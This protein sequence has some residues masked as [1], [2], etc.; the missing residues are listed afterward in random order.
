MGIVHRAV[1]TDTG[2]TVALKTV[3]TQG[4]LTVDAIQREIH[5]L[6]SLDHPGIVR[7]LAHG[8]FEGAPWYAMELLE[9]IDL[10]QHA[11]ECFWPDHPPATVR[12][13]PA[14]AGGKLE[15]ALTL[16]RHLCEALAYLHGEGIVHRD[17]KPQ[18]IWIRPDGTPVLMDFGLIE[19]FDAAAAREV[20]HSGDHVTGTIFYMS[21]EQIRGEL[22]DARTDLY[23][24]GCI[25]YE[26]VTG[27][28]PFQGGDGFE[29]IKLHLRKEP[30]A[31]SLH[32]TGAPPELDGLLLALLAKGPKDRLG[33][34][35]VV[36]RTLA[37]LGAAS[38]AWPGTP[39]RPYLYRPSLAGRGPLLADLT[40]R[41]SAARSG[42]GSMTFLGGA[43]GSGKTRLAIALE[44]ELR[45]AG[46]DVRTG[47]CQPDSAAQ[48]G[49]VDSQPL[50]A[51]R[52]LLQDVA[53]RCRQLGADEADRLL[54]NRG[55]LLALY[56]PS[57]QGLPGQER[58]PEPGPLPLEAARQRLHSYLTETLRVLCEQKPVAIIL[59]DL[60]WA[61]D[62]TLDYLEYLLV[63]GALARL[64]LGLLA[65]YRDEETGPGLGALLSAPG[66]EVVKLE[67][68]QA[69]AIAEIAKD[70]LAI[71]EVPPPMTAF[72][73]HHSE[74]SPFFASE[75]LRTAVAEGL[76]TRT[77]DGSWLPA[78][79][80][81]TDTERSSW[82]QLQV[83]GTLRQLLQR[84]LGTL[85]PEA[86]ALCGAA[87]VLGKEGSSDVLTVTAELEDAARHRATQ[88]LLDRH[89]FEETRSS[90]FRFV[91]ETTRELVLE[92]IAPDRLRT[93]HRTAANALVGAG[94]HEEALARLANHWEQAGDLEQARSCYLASARQAK[95]VYA[96]REAE[97]RY[98][99]FLRL[100]PLPSNATVKARSEL[101]S[102]I[103]RVRGQ[104]DEAVTEL[105]RGIA[106]GEE[107][108]DRGGQVECLTG[109][110][111]I[112]MAT[113]PMARATESFERGVAMCRQ[114]GDRRREGVV[115][116]NL[117]SLRF[118]QGRMDEARELYQQSLAIDRELS[119]RRGEGITLGN[120]A[121]LDHT[122]GHREEARLLYEQA[123][124]IAREVGDPQHEGHL[125]GNLAILA[126]T[127]GDL[128]RAEALYGDALRLAGETGNRGIEGFLL[129]TIGNLRRDQ[130]R[131]GDAEGSYDRALE[132]VREIGDQRIEGFVLADLGE[133]LLRQGR[134]A[135]AE[136]HLGRG[137]DIARGME[138][139]RVEAQIL[140]KLAML[141]RDRG[142]LLEARRCWEEAIRL[143]TEVG[144][145]ESRASLELDLVEV[146]MAMG[147]EDECLPLIED[148]LRTF[149]EA[150]DRAGESQALAALARTEIDAGDLAAAEAHANGAVEAAA[151]GRNPSAAAIADSVQAAIRFAQGRPDDSARLLDGARSLYARLG[152]HRNEALVAL[153]LA[154]VARFARG[155]ASVQDCL[156]RAAAVLEELGDRVSLAR[157]WCEQGHVTLARREPADELL[158]RAAAVAC[159]LGEQSP[160]VRAIARLTRARDGAA[161]GRTLVCGEDDVPDALLE[162]LR[163]HRPETLTG[164]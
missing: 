37:A 133:L 106:D 115:L 12:T 57:L 118:N 109:I 105:Q 132:V 117:A 41:L 147:V 152:Q 69:T 128:A 60:H 116:G 108:G 134:F 142:Q 150:G 21:P 31:P 131:V 61:D 76:L 5:V 137:L 14:A 157:V 107:T 94:G 45:R 90:G 54:G 112:F 162:W 75:Y 34:A 120:L 65:T 33:Y 49:T 42:H 136:A 158:D 51:L 104:Y 113:G 127:N 122:L 11:R 43:G 87:A 145:L 52:K 130:G 144:D 125:L 154:R 81:R 114:D 22:V 88:E 70:M 93:L 129:G 17:L 15:A 149:D 101:A 86:L 100:S 80:G 30:T 83:P 36:A 20:L 58:Y 25:V 123:L 13:R 159:E 3:T 16:A 141:R 32:V 10:E 155:E 97:R 59:D 98:R 62:L 72:L 126:H 164:R 53:D 19:R 82:Q 95:V 18:N 79:A 121:M 148:A 47:S 138:N 99:S 161:A 71:A 151:A 29:V 74:G 146:L 7:I 103:L 143:T 163:H 39:A 119:E 85:S 35:D 135:D 140:A 77:V 110:G 124:A 84:R 4:R 50:G 111:I 26:L 160:L 55:K 89:V 40:A 92:G 73:S 68:L 156:S 139:R 48:A 44:W 56:E 9:G 23:A 28:P 6:A 153:D 102:E 66:V 27:R 24:L 63:S 1:R 2:E 67:P 91:S 38:P 96:H 8:M 78:P 64:R 46:L